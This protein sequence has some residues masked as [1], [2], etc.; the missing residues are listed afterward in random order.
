MKTL[1]LSGLFIFVC[2]ALTACGTLGLPGLPAP[3]PVETGPTPTPLPTSTAPEFPTVADQSC[4]I[5]TLE[6]LRTDAPQGDLLAWQPEKDVLAYAGPA[7]NS[8]WFAGTIMLA[9]GPDFA[10]PVNLAPEAH[11]FGDLT[12][13][14]DG[15]LLAYVSLRISDG[16]YTILTNTPQAGPAQDWL[17]GETANTGS[18]PSSK[19]ISGWLPGPRLSVLSA[20]GPDCDQ[21]TEIDLN[22]GQVSAVGE[23]IRR[24]KDRLAINYHK[25]EY[26]AEVYPY[27]V[28]A[29]WSPDGQKIVYFDE[30][31]RTWVL[32]VKGKEQYILDVGIAFPREAKWSFDNRLLAVRTDDFIYVF[33]TQCK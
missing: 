23:Q 10:A 24:S 18:G 4:L 13:S 16:I 14:P 31:D 8:N 27:M 1:R 33:D 30:D 11:V 12:W 3:P 2:L 32:L 22:T 7:L 19:A 21:I 6:P 28:V 9:S 5:A 20:C 29:D 15:S 17:P 26:D 25:L